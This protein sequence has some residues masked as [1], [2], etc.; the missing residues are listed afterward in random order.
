MVLGHPKLKRKTIFPGEIY[1][2]TDNGLV[3]FIKDTDNAFFIERT[4]DKVS[5]DIEELTYRKTLHTAKGTVIGG[6]QSSIKNKTDSIDIAQKFMNAFLLEYDLR[7]DIQKNAQFELQYEKKFLGKH[8]IQY[9][10]VL[11]AALDIR[12]EKIEKDFVHFQGGGAFLYRNPKKLKE[13]DFYA[14]VD[15][16]NI[17]SLYQ[18]RRRHPI[19]KRIIPHLGVDFALPK[20][21]PIYSTADGKVIRF[22][23]NRAA[24]RYVVIKHKNGY[25]S[26]YNHL[27]TLEPLSKGQR[28]SA[29]DKI[30]SMG[31]T[32]YCTKPH[33]HFAMKKNGRYIDPAPMIYPYPYTQNEIIQAHLSEY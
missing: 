29:G 26:F 14:P 19:T 32:G 5:V 24:G 33:L 10:E 30:G 4:G 13:K 11:Y 3:F 27:H 31:C 2:L 25:T 8:F 18:P 21:S 28:V 20:G 6:L 15:Y 12:G 9:G 7:R 22:G 1:M 23:K 16:L 17:S